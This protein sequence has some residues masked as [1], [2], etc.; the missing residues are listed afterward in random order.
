MGGGALADIQRHSTGQDQHFARRPTW[1]N[2]LLCYFPDSGETHHAKG[3]EY[4]FLIL[5]G[6][7][8][9]L[10]LGRRYI[11]LPFHG[12]ERHK[13][14]GNWYTTILNAHGNTIEHYG[15]YDVGLT[16]YQKGPIQRFLV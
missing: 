9:K 15:D 1:D 16:I 2:A 10:D 4:P 6:R 3:T 14:L 7:N 11:R 13:R 8:A 12:K 5:A